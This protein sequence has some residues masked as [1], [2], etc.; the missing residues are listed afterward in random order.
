[1][2]KPIYLTYDADQEVEADAY[3]AKLK[4]LLDLGIVPT[5]LTTAKDQPTLLAELIRP[6][7]SNNA[8]ADSD[9]KILNMI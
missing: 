2:P 3:V 4:A 8:V 5:E 9:M 7:L 6:Y 1:M